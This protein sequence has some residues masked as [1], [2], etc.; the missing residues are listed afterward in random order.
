MV[1]GDV[2]EGGLDILGPIQHVDEQRG[3]GGIRCVLEPLLLAVLN[4]SLEGD[5]TNVFKG[6]AHSVNDLLKVVLDLTEELQISSEFDVLFADVGV[7]TNG[8][9]QVQVTRYRF[10]CGYRMLIE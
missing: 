1:L 3:L 9:E 2:V 4:V 5:A 7:H 8:N 10:T 6:R